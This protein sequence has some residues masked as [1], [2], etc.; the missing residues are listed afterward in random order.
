M[1]RK[2]DKMIKMTKW[3]VSLSWL[4]EDDLHSEVKTS[5]WVD[6]SKGGAEAAIRAVTDRF[7]LSTDKCQW[8]NVESGNAWRTITPELTPNIGEGAV[9]SA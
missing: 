8:I 1:T 3:S 5:V 6:D 4:D 2:E 9:A 7:G